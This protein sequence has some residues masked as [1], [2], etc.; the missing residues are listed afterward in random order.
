MTRKLLDP[1]RFTAVLHRTSSDFQTHAYSYSRYR[2][3]VA[4]PR[5]GLGWIVGKRVLYDGI[6][7]Y[8]HEDNPTTFDRKGSITAWLVVEK[9][10]RA[11]VYVLEAD[12]DSCE[13]PLATA[14]D[15]GYE[16]GWSDRDWDGS[17]AENPYRD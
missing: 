17:R 1:V 7:R 3:W 12:M 6:A 13:D 4:V 15:E 16:A 10:G 14:W 8:G 11:P 2:K 5:S 9:M